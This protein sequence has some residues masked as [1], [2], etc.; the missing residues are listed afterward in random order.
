MRLIDA[1]ELLSYVDR[2]N[3]CGL[4]KKKSIEYIT[5]YISNMTT[6]YNVDEIV[7][8]LEKRRKEYEDMANNINIPYPNECY[9]RGLMRGYEYSRDIVKVGGLDEL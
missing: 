9:Y 8:E 6:A 4:G 3:N 7:K 5:K 2:V 1:D